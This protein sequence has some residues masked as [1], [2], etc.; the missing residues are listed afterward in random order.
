MPSVLSDIVADLCARIKNLEAARQQ[1]FLDW[2]HKHH[3]TEKPPT[4]ATLS[5]FLS[6][7]W[8]SLP[9]QGSQWEVQLLQDEINWWRHLPAA[10]LWKMLQE[11]WPQ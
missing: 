10:R 6:T 3:R 11:E 4:L 2:L 5:D 8:A 9:P 7:W 1:G